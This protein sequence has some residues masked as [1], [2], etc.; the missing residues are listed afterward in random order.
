MHYDN[1][2]V[3]I[4]GGAGL[5][6]QSL[7]TQ[8]LAQG[9]H[10]R[11]TQYKTRKIALRHK[12]LEI[13]TCDL[14]NPDDARATFRDMD[15]AFLAAAMVGGAKRNLDATSDLIMYN[16]N[17][18][19][20]LIALASKMNLDTCAFISSS[21]VYPDS[22]FPHSESE[23]FLRHPSSYGLGWIKRYLETLCTHFHMTNKTNYAIIRPTTYYGAND[24]FN[25]DECHAIPAFLAKAL[26]S[27]DP[28]EVWGAGNEVR[29][30]TYVEDFT[31][32]LLLAAAEYAVADPI[33]ICSEETHT[34]NDAVSII[35]DVAGYS[36]TIIHKDD[37]PV[38]LPYVV[39]SAN[40]AR[41]LLNWEATTSL[42]QGIEKTWLELTSQARAF[43]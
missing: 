5:V 32:G 42:K 36:P 26:T 6:G 12:N 22:V 23:G 4:A 17:L 33:N 37:A 18:S 43:L 31:E 30:F 19:S 28:F 39:S 20:N 1:K 8:L 40:K 38:S 7:I 41:K 11:A 14:T 16:L 9:A 25:L 34:I 24:N 15:V 29:S 3:L 2:N 10:V 27:M 13:I 35:L 21:F